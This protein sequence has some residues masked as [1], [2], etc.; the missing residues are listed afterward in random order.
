MRLLALTLIALIALTAAC[1]NDGDDVQPSQSPSLT[2]RSATPSASPPTTPTPSPVPSGTLTFTHPAYG[3]SFEYPASWFLFAPPVPSGA[4]SSSVTV[5]TW[6]SRYPPP[7][8]DDNLIKIDI[9]TLE[10]SGHAS[11]DQWVGRQATPENAAISSSTDTNIGGR[12]AIRQERT[13][14]T[15]GSHVSA[16]FVTTDDYAYQIF[17]YSA[18]TPAQRADIDSIVQSVR[19]P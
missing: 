6:D 15:D 7:S 5:A 14:L 1:S 16:I 2:G 19:F 10:N 3:Y 4:T 12:A 18:D 8:G 13:L 9:E 17:A 11:V